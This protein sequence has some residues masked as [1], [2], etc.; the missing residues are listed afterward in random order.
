ML[1]VRLSIKNIFIDGI[2]TREGDNDKEADC[3]SR[4]WL[5]R[6]NSAPALWPC[7]FQMGEETRLF[8]DCLHLVDTC[9]DTRLFDDGIESVTSLIM[10]PRAAIT[11]PGS[12]RD[13]D[14][15]RGTPTAQQH[16]SWPD[17]SPAQDQALAADQRPTPPTLAAAR[18]ARTPLS[19]AARPWV[20][21]A[22]TRARR[23]APSGAG[24]RVDS[25]GGF[26]DD[27][28]M[29]EG[30]DTCFDV[31]EEGYPVTACSPRFASFV[32]LP[33]KEIK[34]LDL[35]VNAEAFITWAQAVFNRAHPRRFH[36]LADV[37][38]LEA[39]AD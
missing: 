39:A 34:M 6:T 13:Q 25:F 38:A 15:A 3:G 33:A 26:L 14:Q 35:V 22:A 5:R 2:S 23:T 20:G 7:L 12:S 1:S 24:E 28:D 11:V 17:Q 18:S 27:L 30:M 37:G 29:L 19:G 4:L 32:G 9:D 8:D 21:A 36:N 31:F 10:S 16:R